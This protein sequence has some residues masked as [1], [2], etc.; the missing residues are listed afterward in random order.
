MRSSRHLLTRRA[1]GL[2][3]SH[4]HLAEL[5]EAPGDAAGDRPRRK[6]ERLADRAIALV[7]GEEAVEDLA[8]MLGQIRQRL[9]DVERLFE[10]GEDVVRRRLRQLLGIGG[11]LPRAGAQAVD[12]ET[13]G[14]LR[15]PGADC[16]VVAERVEPFVD[17][18]EDFLEDVLGVLLGKA[19]SL[20]GDRV[21]V[22]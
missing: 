1:A 10:L 14:E 17:A 9:V 20:D 22:P 5:V 6:L 18:R 13:A 21:D 8:A 7:P 11:E 3:S 15:D 19:E 16:L 4:E 2:V 12:A